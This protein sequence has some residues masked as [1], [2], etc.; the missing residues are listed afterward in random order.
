LANSK[1]KQEERTQLLKTETTKV[2]NEKKNFSI[3]IGQSWWT[4]LM[5]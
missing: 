3:C 4:P 2:H 1:G 5:S